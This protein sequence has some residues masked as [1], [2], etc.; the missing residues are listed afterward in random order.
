MDEKRGTVSE[1]F[2]AFLGLGLT[3]FGGPVAHLGYFREAFVVRRQWLSEA[4]YADLVALCQFLPGPASSQV[5]MALGKLRAGYAGAFAAFAAF[6]LPSVLLLLVFAGGLALLDLGAAAGA[7]HGLK[8]AALAVVLQAVWGMGKALTPDPTRQ[9]IALGAAMAVLLIPWPV[10]Q[11]VVIAAAA[12]AGGLRPADPVPRLAIRPEGLRWIGAFFALLVVLPLLALSGEPS[13]QLI[14]SFYRTGSLVFGGGHVVLP[15]LEAET[16]APG[17]ISRDLFLAGYG[18]AQAVPGPLFSFAAYVGAMLDGPVHGLW[19]AT[20]AL[21]AIYLPSFLLVFGVLP[22][23]QQLRGIVRLRQ[24]LDFANAAVV[25]LLLA[26]LY[27]PVF[28]S[29]VREPTDLAWTLAAFA[30][31]VI[32]RL[33]PWMV[34]LASAA[35]GLLVG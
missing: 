16:V 30:A 1:V 2:R 27:D 35:L 9:L 17:L 14:D 15:L 28:T 8:I 21:C 26:V 18:A 23:W 29:A 3:S 7:L 12:I 4:D 31:L 6:T 13:L 33:P 25:G 19:G 22:L 32:F 11:V 10:M 24:A 20:L 34:V 5:G